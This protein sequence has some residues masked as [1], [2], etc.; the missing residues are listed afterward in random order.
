MGCVVGDDASHSDEHGNAEKLSLVKAIVAFVA[1]LWRS[2]L[3]M[4]A[5]V[6]THSN[7]TP[8]HVR[9]D[10]NSNMVRASIA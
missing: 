1:R 8:P 9:C 4:V 6:G 2:A 7:N 5:V 3:M 10:S